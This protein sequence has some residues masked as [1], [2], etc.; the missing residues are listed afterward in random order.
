V[1]RI[2]E[3]EGRR[4]RRAIVRFSLSFLTLCSVFAVVTST[5][6]ADRLLH[7]P[8]SRLICQLSAPVL[9]LIGDVSSTGTYLSLN[10]FEVSVGEACNGVLPTYI[11]LS[12]VLAFPSRWRDK[13]LGALL[14]TAAIFLINLIRVVTLMVYGAHWLESF[15]QV[16]IYVWQTLVV[17]LSMAVWVFWVERFTRPRA[18]NS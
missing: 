14:G 10:E 6:Q 8:L 3:T 13:A 17:V 2:V 1:N 5:P 15:Q 16:H 12:A 11:F 4:S 9:S 7:E 18:E